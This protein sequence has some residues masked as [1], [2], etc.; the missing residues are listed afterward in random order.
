MQQLWLEK[1]GL[2]VYLLLAAT[3]CLVV[4]GFE[5]GLMLAREAL[6][7]LRHS[8]I[9]ATFFRLVP[10]GNVFLIQTFGHL[11]PCWQGLGLAGSS[12]NDKASDHAWS[13][14]S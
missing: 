10:G 4:L 2:H 6:Y 14:R 12:W 1:K 11:S 13:M 9:P 8:A 3:F 5:L 7:H